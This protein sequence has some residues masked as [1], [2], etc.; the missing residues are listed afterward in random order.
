MSRFAISLT[1]IHP[2]SNPIL[3][4]KNIQITV[5]IDA[6]RFYTSQLVDSTIIIEK[7]D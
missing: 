3:P 4:L 1:E 2:L 5:S 6:V 7:E